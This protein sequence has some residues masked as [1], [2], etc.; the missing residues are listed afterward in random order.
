M[1]PTPQLDDWIRDIK[2][3]DGIVFDDANEGPRPNGPDVVP[4]LILEMH[5]AKDGYTRGK[6]IEL[7]GEIGDPS[8]V[9]LLIAEL[10]HPERAVR[11]SAVAA[12]QLIGGD[13]VN[14][15]ITRYESSQPRDLA[16]EMIKQNASPSRSDS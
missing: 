12:L 8:V 15:A 4:R 11:D 6:F 5:A 14:G 13:A 10:G 1:S 9:P 3:R 7:L 16:G 2:N